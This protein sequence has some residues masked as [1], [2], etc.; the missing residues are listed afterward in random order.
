MKDSG[1]DEREMAALAVDV[2][3]TEGVFEYGRAGENDLA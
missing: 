1:V 3:S 2:R